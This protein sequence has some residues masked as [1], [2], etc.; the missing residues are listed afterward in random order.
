MDIWWSQSSIS[1]KGTKRSVRYWL[2]DV[3]RILWLGL[4]LFYISTIVRLSSHGV[5]PLLF[6]WIS[7]RPEAT[8]SNRIARRQI[9]LVKPSPGRKSHA[10]PDRWWVINW[11]RLFRCPTCCQCGE[12]LL[13]QG[14]SKVPHA[15]YN[16]GHELV[17]KYCTRLTSMWSILWAK[18]PHMKNN[19]CMHYATYNKCMENTYHVHG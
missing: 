15:G 11:V 16:L 12:H 18:L 13:L 1:G 2:V 8:R 6:L 10:M 14:R 5:R 9:G 4:Y 3:V 19:S 17:Q 7:E